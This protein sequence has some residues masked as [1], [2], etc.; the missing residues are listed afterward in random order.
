MLMHSGDIQIFQLSNYK[1][2]YMPHP[3]S[4]GNFSTN[5]LAEFRGGCVRV[6][7]CLCV[8]IEHQRINLNGFLKINFQTFLCVFKQPNLKPHQ[9]PVEHPQLEPEEWAL[10]FLINSGTLGQS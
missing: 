7:L 3:H 5:F 10:F 8:F 1:Y 6:C 2:K 9:A 4:P